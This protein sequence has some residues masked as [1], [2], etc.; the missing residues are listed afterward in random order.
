MFITIILYLNIEQKT[1]QIMINCD[2]I[3]NF[4]SQM[5]IKKWSLQKFVNVSLELKTLNDI[6]FK[7]YE[8]HVLRIKMI[9]S[10][11][12]E[13]R[14]KQ[15]IIV[16]DMTEIDM[17]LNFFWLKKLNSDIDWFFVIMRWRIEN[18]KKSQKRT[19]V[20]IVAIDTIIADSSTRNDAQ[21]KWSVGDSTNLRPN[22]GT[23]APAPPRNEVAK[24]G[25]KP[26][27]QKMDKGKAPAPRDPPVPKEPRASTPEPERPPEPEPQRPVAGP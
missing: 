14:N 19:H 11:K 21:S 15:T 22:R 12:R 23:K 17:I 1:I 13:I 3:F 6:F 10:L 27:A 9:N 8:T 2:A 5:K 20:M 16:A 18:A 26:R 7:C 24:R 4:I 25:R